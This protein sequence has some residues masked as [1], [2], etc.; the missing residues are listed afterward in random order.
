MC[1][2]T[3]GKLPHL[4]LW[5]AH[6]RFRDI[7]SFGRDEIRKIKTNR[8]ELK[9]M[10]AHDFEDMLQVGVNQLANFLFADFAVTSVQSLSSK[11]SSQSHTIHVSSSSFLTWRTGTALRS[12]VCILILH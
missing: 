1:S 11:G 12:Y 7:P 5:S 9:K 6:F 3:L 4:P 8:S 10:T 2:V